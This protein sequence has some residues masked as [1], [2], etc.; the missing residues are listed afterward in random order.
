MSHHVL[1]YNSGAFMKDPILQ[2]GK[3]YVAKNFNGV[4]LEEYANLQ[5]LKANRITKTYTL[6]ESRDGTGSVIYG[7]KYYFNKY[8]FVL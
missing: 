2:D 8:E 5:D 7:G 1:N 6:P 4:T 3:I